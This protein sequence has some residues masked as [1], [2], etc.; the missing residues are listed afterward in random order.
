M[1]GYTS[2]DDFPTTDGAYQTSGGDGF[3]NYDY[4][5]AFVTELNPDATDAIYS[6]FL[7]GHYNTFACDVC[8]GARASAIALSST[9]Y[10]F[11]TGS[12]DIPDFP[13][14]PGAFQRSLPG[15]C[16]AFVT[17]LAPAGRHVAYST[18]L[19][20]GGKNISTDGTGIGIDNSNNAYV[21]G[22][23]DST[24]FPTTPDAFQRHFS[25]SRDGFVTRLA[26][27][28]SSLWYST[29]L[30]GSDYDVANAIAV[31]PRTGDAFVTGNTESSDFPTTSGAFQTRFRGLEDG[32]VT[33]LGPNGRNLTYSTYLGGST[34][35]TSPY[36]IAL[37]DGTPVDPTPAA[38]VTGSTSSADFPLTPGAFQVRNHGPLGQSEGTAFVTKLARAVTLSPTRPTWADRLAIAA[39]ALPSARSSVGS[40]WTDGPTRPIFREPVMPISGKPTVASTP[41]WPGSP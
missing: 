30:G 13:T 37:D 38:F 27:D 29:Y 32:F 20:G 5:D 3:P 9:G 28:G 6:T 7:G 18:Y 16:A 2:S 33:K 41:S 31:Q 25:G 24:T 21:T 12:T 39:R 14:T 34:E 15:E 26:E 11:V 35:G 40:S 17:K 36:G 1:T 22:D 4:A 19:G 10:V 23:T 8:E